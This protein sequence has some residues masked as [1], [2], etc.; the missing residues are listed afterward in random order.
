MSLHRVPKKV[1]KNPPLAMVENP[2]RRGKRFG[3]AVF[4]VAYRHSEDGEAYEHTFTSDD[5]DVLAMPDGSIMLRSPNGER[6][7]EDI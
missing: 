3:T 6:L 7:W 5:V 4:K 2:P 1:L